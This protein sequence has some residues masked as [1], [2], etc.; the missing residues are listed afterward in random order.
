MEELYKITSID[1]WFL[2]KLKRIVDVDNLIEVRTS[3]PSGST[4]LSPFAQA[5]ALC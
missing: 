1:R 3:T 2:Y 4:K 5:S